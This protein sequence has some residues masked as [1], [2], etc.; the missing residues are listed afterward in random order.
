VPDPTAKLDVRGDQYLYNESGETILSIRAGTNGSDSVIHFIEDNATK[1]WTL[2]SAESDAGKFKINYADETNNAVTIDLAGNVSIGTTSAG[3]K[4]DVLSPDAI[5]S[6]MRVQRYDADVPVGIILSTGPTTHLWTMYVDEGSSDFLFEGGYDPDIIF[7]VGAENRYLGIGIGTSTPDTLLTIAND[8]WISAKDSAGTGHV[9]M[10]KVNT[11]NEIEVGGT[12]NIGTIGLAED[13]GVV[14]LVNMPVSSTPIAGTEESYSFAI[15]SEPILKVYSEADG[16]GGIQNKRVGINTTLPAVALD[17]YGDIEADNITLSGRFTGGTLHTTGGATINSSVFQENYGVY[18]GGSEDN[19]FAGKVGIGG[20][21]SYTLHTFGDSM[22]VRMERTGG[23]AGYLQFGMPS[24]VPTIMSGNNLRLAVNGSWTTGGI[25]LKSDGNVGIGATD[26]HGKL[27]IRNG[28]LQ[29]YNYDADNTINTVISS[30][31]SQ[32][33]DRNEVAGMA[34]IN[35]LT[36][37]PYYKGEM[38]FLTAGLDGTDPTKPPTEKMRIDEN[39]NIGIGTNDPQYK[40][41]VRGGNINIADASQVQDSFA[42]TVG[43]VKSMTGGTTGGVGTGSLNQTLRNDGDGWVASSTIYNNGTNVGIGTTNPQERLHV[44]GT[45]LASYMEIEAG[46]GNPGRLI[47]TNTEGSGY[48]DENNNLMRF[49]QSGSAD[50][51]LDD[52][53][54]IGI[55]TTTP[56]AKLQVKAAA[57]EVIVE[58]TDDDG[59]DVM[60]IDANGNVIISL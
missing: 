16:T 5:D 46:D 12:L 21:P 13:S 3:Y 28:N 4:L 41:D 59:T 40:L 25:Y 18:V 9:N 15:D 2:R 14:T 57:A 54:K 10:F 23:N 37:D 52:V 29:L 44:Y 35:F 26:P 34:R 55:G 31:N 47:L 1:R 45:S 22:E 60:Q 43:Y 48:I 11:S 42:A 7:N 27:E 53:G 8:E 33:K 17:V 36:S 30:I 19:Y 20:N 50:M 6:Y 24:A 49:S 51:V 32:I 56:S 38:A 58:F 39:G